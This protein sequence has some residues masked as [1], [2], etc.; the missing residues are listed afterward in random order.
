MES[1][2]HQQLICP[3]CG[4]D[5]THGVVEIRPDVTEIFVWKRNRHFHTEDWYTSHDE[6]SCSGLVTWECANCNT[7]LPEAIERSLEAVV[8]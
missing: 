3:N 5:L 8:Y 4:H 6:S 2:Q 7:R 1:E